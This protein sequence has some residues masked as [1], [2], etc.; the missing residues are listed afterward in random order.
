MGYSRRT[1]FYYENTK[2]WQKIFY[3]S[4]DI[5]DNFPF[6]LLWTSKYRE[7]IIGVI[8]LLKFPWETIVVTHTRFFLSSFM[9]WRFAKKYNL[10]W[11]H[12]EHWSD[13][14]KLSAK[15]KT[16]AAYIYDKIF[17][18]WVIKSRVNCRFS[19]PLIP[20]ARAFDKRSKIPLPQSTI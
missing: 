20:I 18:K 11:I 16:L 7:S 15:W 1:Y 13:Y 6:P 8:G 14:V 4:F 12:I 9:G 17:W 3:D 2:N 5:I 19:K 10:K